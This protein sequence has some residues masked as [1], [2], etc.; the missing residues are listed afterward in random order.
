VS[1]NQFNPLFWGGGVALGTIFILT[2]EL[3]PMAPLAKP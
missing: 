1:K 2:F 3:G